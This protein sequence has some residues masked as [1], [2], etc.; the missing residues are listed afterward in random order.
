MI[1]SIVSGFVLLVI[2][3]QS[4][5]A[6]NKVVVVPLGGDEANGFERITY[7]AITGSPSDNTITF[8]FELLSTL[9]TVA[10]GT[11][12]TSLKVSYNTTVR[13]TG[14]VGGFVEYQ[15]RLNGVDSGSGNTGAVVYMNNA[16]H[17]E[18]V[19][20]SEYFRGLAAG[21][22]D[23]ELWTR[24]GASSTTINWGAFKNNLLI[25][26]VDPGLNVAAL[27]AVKTSESDGIRAGVTQ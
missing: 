1:R 27:A 18:T 6:Q 4:A 21:N 12:S 25:E 23:V 14:S 11:A 9:A 19:F 2:L 8:T 24:G 5:F 16:T 13:Q 3:S 10:K 17:Y 7:F 20:H 22:Y 26:E 15:L